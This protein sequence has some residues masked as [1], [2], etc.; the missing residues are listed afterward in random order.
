MFRSRFSVSD[1]LVIL[2]LLCIA[3]LLFCLHLLPAQ[4]DPTARFL[5]VRTPDGTVSYPLSV[6]REF[7]VTSNGITLVIGIRDGRACVLDANCPDRI[8]LHTGWISRRGE[9]VICAPAAVRLTV[10][11][12]KG[13]DGDADAIIG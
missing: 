13:G 2:S 8:C 12:A 5:S 1:L 4:S 11:D 6:D 7:S 3:G 9:T 10:T